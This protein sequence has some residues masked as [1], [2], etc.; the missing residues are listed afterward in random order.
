MSYQ[1]L[2][3]IY[4][5]IHFLQIVLFYTIQFSKRK[6]INCKLVPFQAIQFIQIVLLQTIKFSISLDFVYTQL[7]VKIFIY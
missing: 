6:Q 7:N 2:L 4:R 1:A 5:Q 3:V